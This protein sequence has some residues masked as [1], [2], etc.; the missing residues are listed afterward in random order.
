[1]PRP[2]LCVLR[3]RQP[4]FAR[5]RAVAMGH[6][7]PLG[8]AAKWV[9]WGW[10]YV[11]AAD[12]RKAREGSLLWEWT[13]LGVCTDPTTTC[14]RPQGTLGEATGLCLIIVTHSCSEHRV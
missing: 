12:C 6:S 8:D 7:F 13:L 11:C 1:M 9:P 14:W 10:R 2:G 4:L 3:T 5:L